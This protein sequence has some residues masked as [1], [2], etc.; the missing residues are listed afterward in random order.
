MKKFKNEG[1]NIFLFGGG[2]VIDH[3]V[4]ADVID[5]Y[6]IGIIPTIEEANIAIFKYIEG[7]YNRKRLHSAINYMTPEECELLARSVS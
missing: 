4:K 1:K 7:W 6:I 5:E 2:V 3:F